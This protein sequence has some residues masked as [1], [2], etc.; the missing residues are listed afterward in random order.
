ML[1]RLHRRFGLFRDRRRPWLDWGQEQSEI[2][3]RKLAASGRVPANAPYLV[4]RYLRPS[5][6]SIENV[7]RVRPEGSLVLHASAHP[8]SARQTVA[9]GSARWI[10]LL[11]LSVLALGAGLA[12]P[13]ATT[14][15]VAAVLLAFSLVRRQRQAGHAARTLPHEVEAHGH[16]LV[17]RDYAGHAE[18][19]PWSLVDSAWVG[20]GEVIVRLAPVQRTTPR[21]LHLRD[22]DDARRLLRAVELTQTW[23]S[24]GVTLPD[25]HEEVPDAALSPVRMDGSG[26][27]AERGLSVAE[28]EQEAVGE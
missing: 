26:V 21:R 7:L 12:T 2:D 8:I 24:E 3:D 28:G 4:Q 18:A 9:E 20:N 27:D 6:A 10:A 19:L 13:W 15:M 22:D 25:L 11:A 16:G 5:P 17:V 23:E 14:A 1:K